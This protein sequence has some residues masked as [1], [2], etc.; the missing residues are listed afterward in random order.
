FLHGGS[1]D[2]AISGAEALSTSYIQLYALSCN[3]PSQVDQCAIGLVETDFF[4]PWNPSDR[5][6][7]WGSADDPWLSNPGVAGR[8]GEFLL[9]N[10][11]DPRREILFNTS[12]TPW[13]CA[14]TIQGGKTCTSTNFD[15]STVV[16]ANGVPL[17]P[18]FLNFDP[19]D[20]RTTAA[21]CIDTRP[22]GI[23]LI[24]GVKVRSDGN[25]AIFGDLGNDWLV[26]GTG[27]D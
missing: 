6:L 18:Y 5:I 9:Y 19:N 8:L 21:G 12:G 10:E 16:D 27:N 22:N 15:L 17:Y 2:D 1:G 11:Y 25:D 20:G 3:D 14:T 4:H 23:C 24:D 7:H 26:G 13:S